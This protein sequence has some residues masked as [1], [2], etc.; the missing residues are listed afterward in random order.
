MDR[1]VGAMGLA[2]GPR[3]ASAASAAAETTLDLLHN[4]QAVSPD[5]SGGAGVYTSIPC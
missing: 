5:V 4:K 2:T 1:W 3:G